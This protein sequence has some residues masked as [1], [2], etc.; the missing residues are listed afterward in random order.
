MNSNING[1]LL[2]DK[3]SG[4]SSNF[5]LQK[6]KKILKLKKAGYIGTLDPIATGMLPICLGKATKLAQYL[7]NKD[8]RYYVTAK[9]GQRTDTLDC[10]GKII[11]ENPV[12]INNSKLK[13]I[14]NSFL[15]KIKQIPPMYSAIKLHNRPLYE[16]ARKGI[17]IS[18]KPRDI[19]IHNLRLI[20]LTQNELALEVHCSKG[21]YI[22]SIIDDLGE[23]LGC[24]AHVTE[25]RR[26]QVG[27]CPINY[28]VT[29]EKLT[30]ITTNMI[31]EQINKKIFSILMPL[32]MSV[33]LLQ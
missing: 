1:I 12:I 11:S 30:A 6:V 16:Y 29:I 25:L 9:L 8:K 13:N 33:D 4:I 5:A 2:L 15:G 18:R 24:G 23:K 14:L 22:R 17:I 7:V 10:Q 21:T 32:N 3:P 28:M 31:N 20:N 26:L 19:I 27:S